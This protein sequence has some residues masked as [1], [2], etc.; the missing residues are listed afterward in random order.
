MIQTQQV[1]PEEPLPLTYRE[2]PMGEVVVSDA[3]LQALRASRPWAMLFAISLFVLAVAGAVLGSISLVALVANR[4]QSGFPVGQFIVVSTGNVLF[5]PVALVGGVLA[6][7]YVAAAGRAY[8]RRCSEE[9]ERAVTAQKHV[10]HW[11][12][13]VVLAVFAF[14]VIVM[15]VAGMMDVWP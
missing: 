15:F 3:A 13:A 1:R 4:R 6:M 7:R 2:A 12:A 8:Y 11:A 5:A 9:L 14:P 10:W